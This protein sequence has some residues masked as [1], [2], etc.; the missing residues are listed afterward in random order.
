MSTTFSQRVQVFGPEPRLDA[1]QAEIEHESPWPC[2]NRPAVTRAPGQL[3]ARFDT[4]R[5][6]PGGATDRLARAWPDLAFL[7]D[8]FDYNT[9][10]FGALLSIGGD[11]PQESPGFEGIPQHFFDGVDEPDAL[12]RADAWLRAK[13]RAPLWDAGFDLLALP[14][15]APA[16]A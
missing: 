8:W 12:A 10:A 3:L 1:L 14:A 16:L 2:L 6:V 15:E 9:S 13:F 5:V 7:H 11:G 4:D